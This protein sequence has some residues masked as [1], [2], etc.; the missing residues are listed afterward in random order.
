MSRSIVYLESRGIS[1]TGVVVGRRYVRAIEQS[2]EH[3]L[4]PRQAHI[5][6]RTDFPSASEPDAPPCPRYVL[7]AAHCLLNSMPLSDSK[8]PGDPSVQLFYKCSGGIVKAD[9]CKSSKVQNIFFPPCFFRPS[10]GALT[11]FTS[12]ESD[13]ALVKMSA[14]VDFG[15]D[16]VMSIDGVNAKVPAE[17]LADGGVAIVAGYGRQQVRRSTKA[18]ACRSWIDMEL[19]TLSY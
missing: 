10:N 4:C 6:A 2:F 7:T 17:Y 5:F 13:I 9:G 8:D 16:A 11:S 1:C 12:I 15:A 14:D 19:K 3:S 18:T